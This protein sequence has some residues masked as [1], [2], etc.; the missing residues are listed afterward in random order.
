MPGVMTVQLVDCT[1]GQPASGVHAQL[2]RTTALEPVC[3][4]I[5][6]D[7][8][9]CY[10]RLPDAPPQQVFRLVV[11]LDSYFAGLGVGP[12]CPSIAVAS[13]LVQ[14]RTCC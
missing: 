6:D 8:G 5:T 13:G 4:E 1:Y 3:T 7:T 9:R 14:P 2:H 11:D 12:S 10:L